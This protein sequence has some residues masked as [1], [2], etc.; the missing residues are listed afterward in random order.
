MIDKDHGIPSDASA[1]GPPFDTLNWADSR[2]KGTPATTEPVGP[3]GLLN[4]LS[5]T[6]SSASVLMRVN[7]ERS[8][9]MLITSR[10]RGRAQCAWG[11]RRRNHQGSSSRPRRT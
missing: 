1:E 6:V 9:F 3:V 2:K 5:P 10:M 11:V 7:D 8:F 4:I